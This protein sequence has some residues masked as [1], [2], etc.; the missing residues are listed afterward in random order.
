MRVYV[1]GKITGTTD[2]MERFQYAEEYLMSLGYTVINP[3]AVN[4]RLPLDTT[5]EEYMKISFT[6]LELCDAIFMLDDWEDSRGA[7]LEHAYAVKHSYT[8]LHGQNVE[9]AV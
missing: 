1:S 2:Y 3:A 9:V 4:A 5:W 6:L 8:I 7:K